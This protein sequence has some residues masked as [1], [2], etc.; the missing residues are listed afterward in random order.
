MLILLPFKS[1]QDQKLVE[2]DRAVREVQEGPFFRCRR[3]PCIDFLTAFRLPKK[4][5]KKGIHSI[6]VIVVFLCRFDMF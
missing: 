5:M 3:K 4:N 6:H 2:S 1:C